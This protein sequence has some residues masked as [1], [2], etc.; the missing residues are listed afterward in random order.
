M[1]QK[2]TN[3]KVSQKVIKR[4]DVIGTEFAI[5]DANKESSEEESARGRRLHA[6]ARRSRDFATV[7]E[8]I[9]Q[10]TLFQRNH[11]WPGAKTAFPFNQKMQTVDKYFPYAEGG[12]LF[13]DQPQ[14]T[15]DFSQFELKEKAMKDLGHRYLLIKPGMTLMECQEA[16]A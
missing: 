3:P 4:P 14:R 12:P 9:A 11:I 5:D 7:A 15:A 8:Q 6:A 1:A 2:Q 13:V 16:L 10:D